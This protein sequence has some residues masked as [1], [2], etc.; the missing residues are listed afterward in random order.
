MNWWIYVIVFGSLIAVFLISALIIKLL[1][2]N[3]Y[4]KA[5]ALFQEVTPKE[6]E[7]YDLILKAKKTMEDDGRFL[8]KNMVE[9]T[10]EVEKEFE[11]IPADIAKIKGMNDF[12]IIYYCKYMKEKK[13]LGKYQDIEQELNAAL[14]ADPQDKRSPYYNYNKA[15][16]KYN[17]YLN[18]G[19]INVFRGRAQRLPTL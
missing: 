18:M 6:K 17:A 16:I 14:H 2:N 5:Y 11:K 15:A 9:S 13:L 8:P 7:R 1:M 12:L 19:F 3:A 10:M 4:K